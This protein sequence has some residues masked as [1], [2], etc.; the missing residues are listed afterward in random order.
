VRCCMSDNASYAAQIAGDADPQPWTA[1][2]PRELSALRRALA[3][4]MRSPYERQTLAQ[5][6]RTNTGTLRPRTGDLARDAEI[7]LDQEHMRLSSA[8]L[9]Y[10]TEDMTRLARAAATTLPVHSF[11]PQ[12]VPAQYGF[13]V[14]GEPIAAYHPEPAPDEVVTIVAASWGPLDSLMPGPPGVWVTFWSMTDFEH[15][16]ALLHQHGVPLRQARDRVRAL[17]AELTWDNEVTLRYGAAELAVLRHRDTGGPDVRTTDLDTDDGGWE[18]IRDTTVAWA[19]ILRATWLLMTQT[20]VT[21]VDEHRLSRTV[22]RHAERQGYNPADIRVVRIRH[23][24][25]I[26]TT[27]EPATERT[28]RV[29]WTVRG[30]WRNQWYP[31]RNEHRPVWINPHI[32][33]PENA[34]LRTGDTVHVLDDEHHP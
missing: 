9:Y 2:Q 29:R 12:D 3:E 27:S 10:V 15:D 16:A 21:D 23:R 13:L 14:F 28:Y 18:Q 26:P 6:L 19:H 30:H 33:G 4:Q 32:K 7:M 11:H 24:D 8:V 22:R 31:S 17:R 1:P 20:G 25:N 5:L 34:P